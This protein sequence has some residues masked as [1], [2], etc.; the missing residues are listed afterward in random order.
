MENEWNRK[1][2]KAQESSQVWGTES[3]L[4]R[5]NSSTGLV[6]KSQEEGKD[7]RSCN[8][9]CTPLLRPTFP[10]VYRTKREECTIDGKWKKKKENTLQYCRK[11]WEIKHYQSKESPKNEHCKN[12]AATPQHLNI[13]LARNNENWPKTKP[14]KRQKKHT[15]KN[16]TSQ[17]K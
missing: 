14:S 4:G 9:A 16:K 10:S 5:V 2:S 7:P 8:T 13:K 12:S 6:T 1:Q 17:K 3:W 15:P 11:T